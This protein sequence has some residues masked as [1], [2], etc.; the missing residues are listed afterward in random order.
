M[1]LGAFVFSALWG[2]AGAVIG[3]LATRAWI[4]S[5]GRL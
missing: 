4:K 1:T 2:V 5:K 3:A